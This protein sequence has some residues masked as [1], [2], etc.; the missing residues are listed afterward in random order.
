MPSEKD[1]ALM[2]MAESLIRNGDPDKAERAVRSITEADFRDHGLMCI[3]RA[4]ATASVR[5]DDRRYAKRLKRTAR[6]IAESI[7][8]SWR[9]D[10]AMAYVDAAGEVG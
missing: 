1:L 6:R 9:R 5:V 2:N 3:A 7:D 10:E 8:T 4:I